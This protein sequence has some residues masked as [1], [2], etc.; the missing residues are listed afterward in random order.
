MKYKKG[1]VVISR[2]DKFVSIDFENS[3]EICD[4]NKIGLI[5]GEYSGQNENQFYW[6]YVDGSEVLM[7]SDWLDRLCK[8]SN[9]IKI[10]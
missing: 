8:I 2:K 6:V 4:E 10:N 9:C 5:I 3:K 7:C 1:D